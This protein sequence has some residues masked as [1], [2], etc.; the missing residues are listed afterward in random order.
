MYTDSPGPFP[1]F[2]PR[3]QFAPP[4]L[5]TMAP[6]LGHNTLCQRDDY[7]FTVQLETTL[8]AY[9]NLQYTKLVGIVFP[10]QATVDYA[11]F[12]RNCIEHPLSDI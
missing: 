2:P 10:L 11:I 12:G 1:N 9:N 4:A 7:I 5:F 8:T 3:W 6:V